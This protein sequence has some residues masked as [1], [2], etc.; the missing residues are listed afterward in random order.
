MVEL[1]LHHLQTAH[2]TTQFKHKKL[3]FSFS[4][5]LKVLSAAV[6]VHTFCTQNCMVRVSAICW[7][8]FQQNAESTP[9]HIFSSVHMQE[10][11]K[12]WMLLGRGS[13]FASHFCGPVTSSCWL[14]ATLGK[15]V[16]LTPTFASHCMIKMQTGRELCFGIAMAMVPNI[17]RGMVSGK[18]ESCG[19]QASSSFH[20]CQ[21][22]WKEPTFIL[23]YSHI[24]HINHKK[25]Q[26]SE[27]VLR[28][29][30][31]QE[32]IAKWRAIKSKSQQ[33]ELNN[34]SKPAHPLL[35]RD[36]FCLT[37]RIFPRPLGLGRIWKARERDAI[38]RGMAPLFIEKKRS[39][40]RLC[41]EDA[42]KEQ[43]W[44]WWRR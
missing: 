9:C 41:C 25:E 16:W 17:N 38:L 43:H 13:T 6:W 36:R 15:F 14:H 44:Q 10:L 32:P 34:P 27:W 7:K 5:L 4:N 26:G 22:F 3:C 21:F 19:G 18:L 23:C 8:C 42:T 40:Y 37:W 20:F 35:G 39:F 11:I 24:R 33:E 29:I 28:T 31:C 2:L 30:S 12:L 1:A